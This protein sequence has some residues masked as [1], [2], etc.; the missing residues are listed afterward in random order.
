[1]RNKILAVLSTFALAFVM[2]FSSTSSA[3]AVEFV[4]GGTALNNDAAGNQFL[5]VCGSN[6]C[7]WVG[8]GK[9]Y[10]GDADYLPLGAGWCEYINRV[11]LNN[12]GT[13]YRDSYTYRGPIN[14]IITN[15]QSFDVR[16]IYPC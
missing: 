16:S 15:R 13:F 14:V 12:D 8:V 5:N 6:G 7:T 2:L 1:M 4:G 3:S 10:Y 9:K 11:Y